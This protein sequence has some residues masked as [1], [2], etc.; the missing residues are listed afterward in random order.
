MKKARCKKCDY[1]WETRSQMFFVS[2]PKCNNKVDI[3]ED[4]N[5]N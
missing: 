1:E 4:K 5:E 2:C 3:R